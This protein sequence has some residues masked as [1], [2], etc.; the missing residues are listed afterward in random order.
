MFFCIDTIVNINIGERF[1][2]DVKTREAITAYTFQM[3]MESIHAET[4]SLQ[5]DN[6]IRES[7]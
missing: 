6:I 2:D 5:I 3:A 7:Y 1:L 4:Y